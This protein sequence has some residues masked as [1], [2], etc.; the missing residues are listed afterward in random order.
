MR[1]TRKALCSSVRTPRPPMKNFLSFN[2]NTCYCS[3]TAKFEGE[4]SSPVCK[5]VCQFSNTLFY[6]KST[7]IYQNKKVWHCTFIICFRCSSLSNG[8]REESIFKTL[9][10]MGHSVYLSGSYWTDIKIWR[11]IRQELNHVC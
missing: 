5:T 7:K 10:H 2:M 8:F 3:H 11:K 6:F 1:F 4:T 9:S